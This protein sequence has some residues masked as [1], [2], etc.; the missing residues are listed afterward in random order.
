[1]GGWGRGGE[2]Y[3]NF[4]IFADA[5]VPFAGAYYEMLHESPHI[6]PTYLYIPTNRHLGHEIKGECS[7]DRMESNRVTETTVCGPTRDSLESIELKNLRVRQSLPQ[8]LF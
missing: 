2:G 6:I 7:C 8:H 1:M 3:L 4:V 5:S